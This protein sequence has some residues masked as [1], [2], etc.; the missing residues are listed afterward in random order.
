MQESS[1]LPSQSASESKLDPR[2][3]SVWRINDALWIVVCAIIC[4]VPFLIVLLAANEDAAWAGT[5]MLL[6]VIAAV[7]LLVV[8]LGVLPSIRYARWRYRVSEDYLEIRKGIVWR[9]HY[10]IPFIRVQNTDTRQGPILRAFGLASVT[11]ATA[12]GEHEIPGLRTQDAELLRDKAAELA[13]LARE[14]V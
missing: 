1:T 14:D 13:R 6:E 11:V 7:A 5:V 10:V 8:F 12:A 9:K 3:K 4:I 2:I